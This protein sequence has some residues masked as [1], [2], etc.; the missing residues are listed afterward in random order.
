MTRLNFIAGVAGVELTDAERSIFRTAAPLGLILFDRNLQD[1]EQ[2]KRLIGDVRHEVGSD[3]FWVLIDQ[4]G[5]RVQRLRPPLF[6]ALPAMGRLGAFY[7]DQPLEALS[8]AND[9]AKLMGRH[10]LDFGINVNCTPV[11]DVP[12]PGADE[13]IGNRSFGQ[14]IDMI[15]A[16]GMAIAL[17][18][19]SSGVLPVI[20]HIPGHGRAE[21]DSHKALPRIASDHETLSRV[22]FAPFKGLNKMP[23]AMTAHVLLEAIDPSDPVSVSA[24]V[25]ETII[26]DEI[27]FDGFLMSDDVSME[28]L[29]GSI[30]ERVAACL[31][32]GCDG[33]LHCN[34]DLDELRQVAE[35]SAVLAD[36]AQLRFEH[37]F[38]LIAQPQVFDEERALARLHEEWAGLA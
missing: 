21:A 37:S 23:L 18:H 15:V 5:G 38:D 31:A 27:G 3:Q 22:D 14:D 26:R 29:E 33:A 34:G 36:Q 8:A 20:K 6:P 30:G 16:L 10:L 7:E 13:I 9:I 25:I 1:K 12:Q 32:A 24:K 17:G 35:N 2:I 19:I 4:E 28:A 11:L